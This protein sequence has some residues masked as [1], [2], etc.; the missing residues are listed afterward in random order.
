[1]VLRLLGKKEIVGSI[2]TEGSWIFAEVAQRQVRLSCKEEYVGSTPTY[3]SMVSRSANLEFR[4]VAASLAA[5]ISIVRL[6]WF[7]TPPLKAGTWVQIPYDIGNRFMCAWP[8]GRG[9][10]L[11][12]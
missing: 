6:V 3:G 4:K 2:P 7:R 10:S 9:A 11:P 8:S 5:R 1:M 12:N